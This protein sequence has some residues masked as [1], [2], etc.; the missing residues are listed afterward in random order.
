[1]ENTMQVYHPCM[2]ETR[3]G[4]RIREIKVDNHNASNVL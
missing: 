2:S 1:L 3:A 4:I